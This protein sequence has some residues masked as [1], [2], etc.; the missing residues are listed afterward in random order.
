MVSHEFPETKRD[1]QISRSW[2]Y[3]VDFSTLMYISHN[4]LLVKVITLQCVSLCSAKV[5]ADGHI[6]SHILHLCLLGEAC[7]FMWFSS[8]RRDLQD[9]LQYAQNKLTTEPAVE[10]PLLDLW[11]LWRVDDTLVVTVDETGEDTVGALGGLSEGC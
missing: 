8:S 5:V 3:L 9:S 1:L 6:S 7:D 4:I 2:C 11:S 10:L